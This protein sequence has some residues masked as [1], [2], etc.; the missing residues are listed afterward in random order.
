SWTGPQIGLTAANLNGDRAE[1][2]GW[3]TQETAAAIFDGAGLDF[4]ALQAEAA[5][6]GFSAVPMS[7][8]RLNVS[9]ENSVR[10]S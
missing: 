5:Q 3:V 10:T 9:V 6:P 1:I 8:L 7:D 2:E 4:Q